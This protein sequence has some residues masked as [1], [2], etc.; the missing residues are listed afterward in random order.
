MDLR[1]AGPDADTADDAV[2]RADAP[3]DSTDPPVA[4][5]REHSDPADAPDSPPTP[6]DPAGARVDPAADAPGD[7]AADAAD[8]AVAASDPAPPKSDASAVETLP[9]VPLRDNVVFPHQ[10]APLGAGRPRSVAALEAAVQDHG[11]TVVLA[12][13]RDANVDDVTLADLHPVAVVATV[14][15][16]RRLGTGGAQAL[17]EGQRRVR[18]QELRADGEHWQAVVTPLDDITTDDTEG[19]ALAGNVRAQFAEY[20]G[21]GANVAAEVVIALQRT[22]DA[23]RIADIASA[24]PDLAVA[25]RL[26][27]LIEPDV[28]RRLKTLVPLLAHL[29]EV[30]QLRSRIQEDVQRTITRAQREAILREQLKS[31]RRELSELDGGDGEHDEEDLTARVEA[32]GMPEEI[33]R[34]ALKE[35]SRLEQI[36]SASP[37]LG[38][39]RNYVDWML[40]LPWRDP[41]PETV[42]I[43]RAAAVLDEDH[44]GLEKVK[45]RILEWMAVRQ[46]AQLRL[47][48]REQARVA[49]AQADAAADAVP[50]FGLPQP[51]RAEPIAPIAATPDLATSV[52]AEGS[53]GPWPDGSGEASA[54]DADR[55]PA[56]GS[57]NVSVPPA[58]PAPPAPRALQTPILCF[59]GPPGVG[60]TSLGRSVARA[61][62]RKF[63]RL[64]LGGI[65]DEAEIRGHRRT[66]IGALPGRIIQSMKQAGT[67]NPVIMLD[68]IDKVGAD[69]RGDPSAALLEVLDPEQ[70]REF[71]DHYLEVPYDLS[72]VLFITTA[73]VAE[74]ISPPLRDRMEMIRITGYTEAEKQGIAAHHLL[75]EQLEQHG[76]DPEELTVT[77]EAMLALIRGWTREAGVR[78]LDRTLAQLARKV[79]RRLAENSELTSVVVTPDD[80][81]GMLGPR[82][83]DFG[84]QEAQDQVGAVT[85]CVVSEVGGDIVTVEALAIDGRNDLLLTGQLGS[86]MEESARAALSWARVHAEQW[87][88]RP[89]FFDTHGVH[90]HV[91]AGGIPKDGPS[92]G[93]TMTTA[94]VSVA[95][96]RPV[97]RDVAMTGEV[98]LRGRVL[99]IGGVKDKLLAAHRAGIRT[100]ILPKRNVRDLHDVDP[101][102]IGSM[103][104]VGVDTVD[105]VLDRALLTA[106]DQRSG[107]QRV[108]FTMRDEGVSPPA[109]PAPAVIG[110]EV[111]P[112]VPVAPA[113]TGTTTP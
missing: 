6:V 61:L 48:A 53:P 98:T 111:V 90:I 9:L 40:D 58:E 81:E 96:H 99:P 93:I 68:E 105:E 54:R 88:A 79:P 83:H 21:A 108:G 89:G 97:R 100:F 51:G 101:E 45:E 14:G 13:Q 15:A 72:Q 110:P 5:P 26:G 103:E 95:A 36:P 17:V 86:V 84:E 39:V 57:D 20:A 23:G 32:A 38:M 107:R 31:V 70:N 33:R 64:S 8:P 18:L 62:D 27:L 49:A 71:S 92:A 4:P 67:R 74:T 112:A 65:R 10:L 52:A 63:V 87:G 34:R 41:P 106:E 16:L 43:V 24:A 60:K 29:V 11:G 75:P 55:E 46:R 69:F 25:D 59:V 91:P 73:N 42:D 12:V 37:E 22:T 66:Y 50:T 3:G 102:I 76:L 94:L 30:A 78:Q 80:L 85:G 7:P 109:A 28:T 82:R 56:T 77:D 35:V 47:E 19:Q 44:F 2:D 113:A 1:D 104:I